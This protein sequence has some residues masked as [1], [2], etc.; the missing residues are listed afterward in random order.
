AGVA[1]RGSADAGTG[2]RRGEPAAR[3]AVEMV[4]AGRGVIRIELLP[5]EAPKAVR[6]FLALVDRKF[7][8]GVLFHRVEPKQVAQ[9]GDPESRAVDGRKIAGIPSADAARLYHLGAGGS[10]ETVPLE[11]GG[12]CLRGTIGLARGVDPNSGDSQFFFNLADNHRLDSQYTVFGRVVSGADVMDRIEQGDR[13][14]SIRRVKL[15]AR[16][17]RRGRASR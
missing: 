10:G 3:P 15:S 11:A 1:A 8:D 17:P 5:R 9:A 12:V 7:Y 6:H 2:A 14:K 4:I 16:T 13:V